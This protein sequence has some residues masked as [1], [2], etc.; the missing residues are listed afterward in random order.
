M[1]NLGLLE[2]KGLFAKG[3]SEDIRIMVVD[4]LRKVG[5]FEAA[6]ILKKVALRDSASSV[7]VKA[8]SAMRSFEK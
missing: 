6:S 1:Q 5:G 3:E 8:V 7:K 4:A 2:K